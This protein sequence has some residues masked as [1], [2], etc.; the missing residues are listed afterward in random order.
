M[1]PAR[2]SAPRRRSDPVAR[3]VREAALR[4]HDRSPTPRFDSPIER[5]AHF[6]SRQALLKHM[7]TM[8]NW[9]PNQTPVPAKDKDLR[10]VHCFLHRFD[11][12]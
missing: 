4:H 3:N 12:A 8:H 9:H 7:A 1:T 11:P 10:K 2:T 5:L 6:G